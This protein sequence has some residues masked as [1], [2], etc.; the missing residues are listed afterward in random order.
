[1]DQL[2]SWMINDEVALRG[3]LQPPG[4]LA[5]SK[6]TLFT[7]CP[8][9]RRPLC[10]V[11]PTDGLDEMTDGRG[12]TS[13]T[14]QLTVL[15]GMGSAARALHSPRTLSVSYSR[16]LVAINS[17]VHGILV[18]ALQL[19]AAAGLGKAHQML[20]VHVTHRHA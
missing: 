6:L 16:A 9:A 13:S 14:R 17:E 11:C 8:A 3:W 7:S 1:M 15:P 5:Q 10:G 4:P 19:V 2:P 18:H 20:L 12:A